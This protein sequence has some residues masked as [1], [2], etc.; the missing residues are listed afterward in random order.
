L[1]SVVLSP[2]EHGFQILDV[3]TL[4][5]SPTHSSHTMWDMLMRVHT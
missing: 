5:F 4:F 2:E 3:S 1:L